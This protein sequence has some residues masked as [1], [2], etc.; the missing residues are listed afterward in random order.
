MVMQTND[1]ATLAFAEAL[2]GSEGI[3]VF[4]LDVHMSNLEGSIGILPRRLAVA[5]SDAERARAILAEN[6]LETV[7]DQNG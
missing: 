2:L 3:A 5:D 7:D 4:L 1:P 6:G